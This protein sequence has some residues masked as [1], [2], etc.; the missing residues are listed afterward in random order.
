MVFNYQACFEGQQ[1]RKKARALIWTKGYLIPATHERVTDACT[2]PAIPGSVLN[3]T[4]PQPHLDSP[5][6]NGT[7]SKD[8]LKGRKTVMC[9]KV[10]RPAVRAEVAFGS[11]DVTNAQAS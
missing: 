7:I 4:T 10:W 8:G 5:N 3:R 11:I 2:D 9:A 1:G 6:Q